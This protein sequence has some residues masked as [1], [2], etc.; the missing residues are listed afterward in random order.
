[1]S[2]LRKDRLLREALGAQEAEL[3][4]AE[5]IVAL[6]SIVAALLIVVLFWG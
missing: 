1:M 3:P 4:R 6:A 5:G 2:T